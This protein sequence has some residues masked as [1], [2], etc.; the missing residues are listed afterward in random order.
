MRG[1]PRSLTRPSWTS[2]LIPACAGKT[3][4][5]YQIRR[6][7]RAHPRVC[8][9]NQRVR[10]AGGRHAGS[11]PRVRGKRSPSETEEAL[12]GLIPA[13]AGKTSV[14]SI[15]RPRTPAHPRVCGE[16]Y[17]KANT[18]ATPPRLIPACAGKTPRTQYRG[19]ECRAHPRVCGENT[20][21]E[22]LTLSSHGS[23][24]RVRGKPAH[25][26][27]GGRN[28]RLIPACAG[29]TM[30]PPPPSPPRSAHPRVCGENLPIRMGRAWF[31]GSSP[32]VRGKRRGG[33]GV[34]DEVGL[35]PA[36][37]GKTL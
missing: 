34:S 21:F 7:P 16:N 22:A 24:P 26:A 6:H 1:K 36:C 5:P 13:C 11:S 28:S 31:T 3:H 15:A 20:P 33:V 30:M 12:R 32:R 18:V 9:E 27:P 19:S 35:I 29:K 10:R 4:Q 23:S 25:N 8:G 2:G 17:G 37:A 14:R